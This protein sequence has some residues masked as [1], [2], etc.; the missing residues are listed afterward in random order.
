MHLF[1]QSRKLVVTGGDWILA[2][3]RSTANFSVFFFSDPNNAV[4]WTV[5]S[6]LIILN[7]LLFFNFLN[8]RS[9]MLLI[10]YSNILLFTNIKLISFWWL[11]ICHSNSNRQSNIFHIKTVYDLCERYLFSLFSQR[12]LPFP[13]L[14]PFL[15][16][17]FFVFLL[18]QHLLHYSAVD[19][20]LISC[21]KELFATFL[22]F[23][24][25]AHNKISFDGFFWD[26][27]KG[28]LFP[29]QHVFCITFFTNKYLWHF[30]FIF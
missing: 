10:K 27:R 26:E 28:I 24:Y 11:C 4:G 25:F 20:I 18:K 5:F 22:H 23:D 6:L 8:S 7:F 30:L 12:R 21:R 13:G 19:S 17:V 14:I 16:Q 3:I 9:R 1:V 29:I 15:F 2:N